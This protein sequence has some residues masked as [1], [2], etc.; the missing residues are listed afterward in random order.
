MSTLDVLS[1]ATADYTSD[2]TYLRGTYAI[3]PERLPYYA[4]TMSVAD[5]D[6]HLVLARDVVFD[7]TR[8]AKLE[9]LF[10]RDLDVDRARTEIQ[11]YLKRPEN[12]KFFNSLTVVLMPIEEGDAPIP[13]D[14][15]P[16]SDPGA[17]DP[18]SSE[19]LNRI[20]V[21]PIQIRETKGGDVGFIRWNVARIS[22]V[23]IDGQHRLFALRELLSDRAFVKHLNPHTTRIPIL[24]LV[25]DDRVGYEPP[26]GGPSGVLS[27]CRVIFVDINKNAKQVEGARLALLND[28]SIS[29]CSMRSLLTDE[30]GVDSSPATNRSGKIPLALVDWHSEVTKF[31]RSLYLSS[32]LVLRDV[33]EQSLELEPPDAYAHN[34]WSSYL[35]RIEARLTPDPVDGWD[36]PAADKRL[37]NAERDELPFHLTQVETRAAAMGYAR[38]PGSLV[39]SPLLRAEPY[40]QLVDAYREVGLIDGKFELWLGHD[41]EGKRAFERY[42]DGEVPDADLVARRVKDRYPLAFQVVFQKGILASLQIFESEREESLLRL[43]GKAHGGEKATRTALEV[44][45]LAKF[46]ERIAPW[47]ADYNFWRGFGVRLDGTI[48]FT[49]A[50]PSAVAG[51]VGLSL[52][53][54]FAGWR[55]PS[56]AIRTPEQRLFSSLTKGNS[57]GESL[58]IADY[59]GASQNLQFQAS[60]WLHEQLSYVR[61][62]GMSTLYG[63]VVRRLAGPWVHSVERY[64]DA[65]A[66]AEASGLLEGGDRFRY[67]HAVARAEGLEVS[68]N[69]AK[70]LLA[71]VHGGRRLAAIK[72]ALK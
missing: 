28:R 47:L 29:D 45:W 13:M 59:G 43:T 41:P 3:G 30:I 49:Q 72:A 25:L 39:V 69:D 26:E 14:R 61:P 60:C 38:G 70:R 55:A 34:E 32:V 51:F 71:A 54:P 42:F 35:N 2:Y 50:A 24:A 36:R 12:L 16:K 11:T 52:I 67:F 46:D 53:A 27:A 5:A 17:P 66:R 57:I 6:K 37:R 7:V 1:A 64:L 44:A 56:E 18:P 10:Q 8:P 20:D 63:Y 21:G 31:D 58:T 19:D 9:E 23:V 68:D 48:D 22:P 62:G 65:A 40:A 4:L 15:Y 33:V